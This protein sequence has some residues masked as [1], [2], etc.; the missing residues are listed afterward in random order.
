[1]P[2]QRFFRLWPANAH[3]RASV[4]PALLLAATPLLAQPGDQGPDP[5]ALTQT[6]RDDLRCA[7]AFAIVALE[8]EQAQTEEQAGAPAMS[9]WPPL[10]QRGKTFFTDTGARVMREAGLPR[11]AVRALLT[12]DVQALQ[13]APDPDLALAALAKPC[14]ARL[15]ATVPP[16]KVPDLGQC[17]AILDLAYDEVHAREGMSAAARDLKTLAM[18][19]ADRQRKAITNSG[20]SGTAADE[21]LAQAR[22]AMAAEAPGRGVE[23]YDIAH[24]YDLARPDEKSHY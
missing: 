13:S 2:P 22:A 5:A 1:M 8:Q 7:A 3:I 4:L 11:D 24:C 23:H 10:G 19:L 6:H 9:G 18:V 15:E 21:A 14:V 17:A 20:G 16:L 12:A